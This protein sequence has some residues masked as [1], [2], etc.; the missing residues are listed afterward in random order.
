MGGAKAIVAIAELGLGK[1]EVAIDGM[2]L[3]DLRAEV[4]SNKTDPD[5]VSFVPGT[6]RICR[7]RETWGLVPEPRE[8]VYEFPI[9][10]SPLLR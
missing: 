10:F 9:N 5:A 4:G 7:R 1:R 3:V 2:I 6:W 8:I